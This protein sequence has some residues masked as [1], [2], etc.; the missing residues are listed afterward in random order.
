[1]I[2]IIDA[3][4]D[5]STSFDSKVRAL[6]NILS[7][8]GEGKHVLWAPIEVV[9][10]LQDVPQLSSYSKRVLFSLKST[11]IE[12]RRI[13]RQFDFHV[14][15]E[16]DDG[17]RMELG[18]GRLNVGFN[19][20]LDTRMLQPSILITENLLDASALECGAALHLVGNKLLSAFGVVLDFRPG[21]GSTTYDLFKDLVSQGRFLLCVIDSDLK[22]PKGPKGSTAKRFRHEKLGLNLAYHLEILGC[23]EIENILPVNVVRD[24]VPRAQTPCLLYS[25]SKYHRYRP[26]PDHKFGLRVSTARQSDLEFNSDY[27][28]E[29]NGCDDEVWICAPLGESLL[30]N[31]VQKMKEMSPHKLYESLNKTADE[32][33][34]R[35]SKLVASWGVGVR[36][37]IP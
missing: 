12:T 10:A 16:F 34:M 35:V 2:F 31:S 18:E 37:V 15:V 23:H 8:H 26:Y 17:A 27:W 7:A 6:D 21:G 14:V 24:L 33:W 36:R 32:E 9:E 25:S 20:F 1:M 11:V 28:S 5:F 4:I 3:V 29:F 13:E 19:Y 30:Q 22:H